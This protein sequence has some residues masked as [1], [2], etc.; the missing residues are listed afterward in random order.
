MTA[1]TLGSIWWYSGR[2]SWPF[3]F[4]LPFWF[5]QVC[6]RSDSFILCSFLFFSI[7]TKQGQ[8]MPD[9]ILYQLALLNLN[10]IP[11]LPFVPLQTVKQYEIWHP[12][13]LNLCDPLWHHPL[14]HDLAFIASGL[15]SASVVALTGTV[16]YECWMWWE[17]VMHRCLLRCAFQTIE[18]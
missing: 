15:S 17:C 13:C 14:Q 16:V 9:D 7:T 5:L 11:D 1:K 6:E 18:D 8:W 2:L 12:P 10:L 4:S 3:I